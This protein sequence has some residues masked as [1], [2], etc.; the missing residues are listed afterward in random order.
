MI[1]VGAGKTRKLMSR[2]KVNIFLFIRQKDK[3]NRIL[4]TFS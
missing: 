4:L 3:K 2:E 1:I